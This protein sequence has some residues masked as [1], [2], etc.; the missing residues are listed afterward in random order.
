MACGMAVAGAVAAEALS[1]TNRLPGG[2]YVEFFT[3]V[4]ACT[5]VSFVVLYKLPL[6]GDFGRK[7]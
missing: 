6:A 7:A 3:W 4:M 2:G 1:V 5:L